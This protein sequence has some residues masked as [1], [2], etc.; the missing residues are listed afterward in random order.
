MTGTND[1]ACSTMRRAHRGDRC[2]RRRTPSRPAAYTPREIRRPPPGVGTAT[3]T[4]SSASIS[5]ASGERHGDAETRGSTDPDAGGDRRATP[6]AT[7]AMRSHEALRPPHDRQAFGKGREPAVA[8]AAPSRAGRTRVGRHRARRAARSG[9]P[10]RKKITTK[11]ATTGG[12]RDGA[13]QLRPARTSVLDVPPKPGSNKSRNAAKQQHDRQ[14]VE[15]RSTMIVANVAVALS[16]PGAPAGT[17]E[18]LRRRAPAA[19]R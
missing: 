19:P 6:P 16:P 8:A 10:A 14:R 4:T 18:S 7:S 15:D 5:H 12:A 13:A 9:C 1:T 11:P 2:R 17:A 3:P